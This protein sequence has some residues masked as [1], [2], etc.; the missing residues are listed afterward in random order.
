M[1]QDP[2]DC[3]YCY[4]SLTGK[5]HTDPVHP[6]VCDGCMDSIRQRRPINPQKIVGSAPRALDGDPRR[7]DDPLG[8]TNDAQLLPLQATRPRDRYS[9]GGSP[10]NL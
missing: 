3:V 9:S 5:R 6:Y 1:N 2:T 8:R 7:L 4:R 10:A